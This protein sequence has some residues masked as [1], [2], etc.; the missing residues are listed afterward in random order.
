[1]DL[2]DNSLTLERGT[3]NALSRIMQSA[4]EIHSHQPGAD[5][6]RP[7]DSFMNFETLDSHH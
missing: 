5:R 6:S 1:M 4:A 7:G 2:T 3:L